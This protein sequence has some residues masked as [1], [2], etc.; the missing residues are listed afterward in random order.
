MAGGLK[1]LVAGILS[2]LMLD[3]GIAPGQVYT[4]AG[5]VPGRDLLADGSTFLRASYPRLSRLPSPPPGVNFATAA[6][7]S[8]ITAEPNKTVYGNNKMVVIYA[9]PISPRVWASGGWSNLNLGTYNNQLV[10]DVLH[11]GGGVWYVAGIFGVLRST[12]DLVSFTRV[13]APTGGNWQSCALCVHPT[14]GA[15]SCME[16]YAYGTGGNSYTPQSSNDGF[17]FRYSADGV[18]WSS[19][20]TIT[21]FNMSGGYGYFYNAVAPAKMRMFVQDGF[22]VFLWGMDMFNDQGDIYTYSSRIYRSVTPATPGSWGYAQD[23]EGAFHDAIQYGDLI[24]VFYSPWN[25]SGALYRRAYSPKTNGYVVTRYSPSGYASNLINV[26]S[27]ATTRFDNLFFFSMSYT[28]AIREDMDVVQNTVDGNTMMPVVALPLSNV[29]TL[30]RGPNGLVALSY[31]Y[32]NPNTAYDDYATYYAPYGVL[33][34]VAQ[35]GTGAK[36]YV[37]AR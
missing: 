29:R 25:T 5:P 2:K 13:M 27:A 31:N 9:T 14:S 23:I 37:R 21:T 17:R 1:G 22:Y 4:Q 36:K 16:V 32:V 10:H 3:G 7:A 33:P 26:S 34:T 12:D 19:S 24:H 28:G 15:V 18:T 11:V 35:E 6:Q 8:G 30:G 20:G